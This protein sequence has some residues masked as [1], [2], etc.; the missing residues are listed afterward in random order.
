LEKT[1]GHVFAETDGLLQ[2]AIDRASEARNAGNGRSRGYASL[3]VLV[4]GLLFQSGGIF[5]LTKLSPPETLPIKPGVTE[6]SRFS[7]AEL[8]LITSNLQR[9]TSNAKDISSVKQRV[10][11]AMPIDPNIAAIEAAVQDLGTVLLPKSESAS[12]VG[13]GVGA[14]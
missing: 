5:A 3:I 12:G 2:D 9:I 4:A 6:S 8:G 10:A 1:S 14:E 11:P 13:A 7:S